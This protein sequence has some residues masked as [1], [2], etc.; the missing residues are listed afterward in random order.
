M[1]TNTLRRLTL[2][3]SL[4]IA[5]PLPLFASMG[6]KSGDWTTAVLG[7]VFSAGLFFLY[8]WPLGTFLAWFKG[9]T[10]SRSLWGYLLSLP[11]YYLTLT[12]LYPLFGGKFRPWSNGRWL[13]YLSATPQFYVMV[14]FVF[15]LSRRL[16]RGVLAAA[17]AVFA[18]GVVAVPLSVMATGTLVW[19]KVQDHVAIINARI[20]D[21][22]ASR[23]VEGQTVY[24]KDG[25]IEEIGPQAQHHDWPYLDAQG[26]YL[27]PGLIDVHTHLQ[28][29]IE[30]PVGFSFRYFLDSMLRNYAPQRKKYLDNGITSIRDLGGSAARGFTLRSRI[31]KHQLLGP[32][33]FFVGRLVTSPHGHPVSTIW[34]ASTTKQGA[35]LAWDEKTLLDGL[36]KNLAA[37]P[38]AVKFVHGTIGRA[39]EE[40]SADFLARG[41]RWASEHRLI[42][43][44]HAETALEF[45][46]AISAGATGVEHAAYLQEVPAALA[47]L[48]SKTHP[49]IDPTFGEYET[50]LTMNNFPK[51]AR[52]RRLE[53]SY[54]AARALRSAGAQMVVG[55]DAPMTRYGSGLHDEL[56]HFAK[57]GFSSEEI[58]TF[59]T[60]NNA[61]Y[62]GKGSELGQ[63]A[64][65]YRADLILVKDNPLSNLDTLRQPVW[66]MLDG[67]VV[68][69]G[70][71]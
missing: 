21:T 58:L 56:A 22:A 20:V 46:D 55:T 35:I 11:L 33:L 53:S 7:L 61:A 64:T 41:I 70:E 67:Q 54:Q 44:V 29:P 34:E 63:V 26:Q 45:E 50:D 18:L 36:N 2:V 38:D 10:V 13:I 15:Y 48:V 17:I 8:W 52:N 6:F 9:S 65:G 23:I 16:A 27:V 57:A 49:F 66:T 62:L 5:S 60:V 25:R 3:S 69:H 14:R 1:D 42:S 28:S 12:A 51:E 59:V 39:K 43:V 37:G 40:L 24:I 32:R 47:A 71:K 4:F 19:S 68:S 31:N 30:V